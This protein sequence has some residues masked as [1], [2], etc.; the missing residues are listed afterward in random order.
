MSRIG[1]TA[2]AEDGPDWH[3]VERPGPHG[4]GP[5]VRVLDDAGFEAAATEI[6]S[7]P[8]YRP[9]PL[10]RLS[11]PARVADVASVWYK[12]ESHRFGTGS[13]KALGG[14][15]GVT[16]VLERASSSRSDG[17]ATVACATAG[18]HGAAV[19]WGARRVGARSVVFLP[20]GASDARE[21]ALRAL[22]AE[23]RR[24]GQGY[25]ATVEL[26]SEVADRKGWLVVS[27]TATSSRPDRAGSAV[28][29]MQGYRLLVEEVLD[30]L[31]A[32]RQPTHVFV[33]AGVG[34]LAGAV[35]EHLRARLG[36][37]RPEVI[38]VEAASAACLLASARAGGKRVL[39]AS[40]RTEMT[41]LAC[42]TPSA[43]AWEILR[44]GAR[45][46][47]TVTDAEG[48]AAVRGLADGGPG[49]EGAAD[50]P[51]VAGAS[52]AAGLAGL[53]AAAGHPGPRRDLGL[54]EGSRVLVLGT[55]GATDPGAYRRIVGR[56]ADEVAAARNGRAR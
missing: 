8:G 25:D 21:E 4:K 2:R 44:E 54:D 53:L 19:A 22:G 34:G 41:G 30:E 7:W 33:Q 18:N 24:T 40:P 46:F 16:R 3:V 28:H 14:A 17:R 20:A 50:P 42:R 27:D 38:V 35:C 12:D 37:V 10:L 52:G 9:T 31:P 36:S 48:R 13:F 29:V 39:A 23:V 45:G 55:E 6:R 5:E 51:V 26:A 43:L 32:S 49:S 1:T 15:Y 11:G 56:P 47:L